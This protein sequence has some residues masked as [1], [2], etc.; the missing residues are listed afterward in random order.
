MTLRDN[1]V[2]AASPVVVALHTVTDAFVVLE[3]GVEPA[4]HVVSGFVPLALLA[5]AVAGYARARPGLRAVL[6][7]ALGALAIVQLVPASTRSG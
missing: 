5:A 2:F 6:A 4:D 7:L 3:S 1:H